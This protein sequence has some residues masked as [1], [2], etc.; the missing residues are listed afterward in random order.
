MAIPPHRSPKIKAK[1]AQLKVE[2]LYKTCIFLVSNDI[3][4]MCER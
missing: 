1:K 3:S 4:E 2:P